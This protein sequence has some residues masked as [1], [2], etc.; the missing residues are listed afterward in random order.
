[1]K[2]WKLGILALALIMVVGCAKQQKTDKVTMGDAITITDVTSIEDVMAN[3]NEYLGKEI[4]ISGHVNGRCMGSGCWISLKT[5]EA[6]RLII[7]APDKSFIFSEKC[8]D[9]DVLIQGTLMVKEVAAHDHG[10]G[11]DH[12]DH[13]HAEGTPDHECPDPEYYFAPKG[14]EVTA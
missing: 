1:M 13:E 3:P 4:V 12:H 14:V 5:G 7:S 11:E 10:E 2:I 6:D 8:V 9:Q